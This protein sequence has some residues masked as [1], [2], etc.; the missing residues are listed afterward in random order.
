MA[1]P[2]TGA[3]SSVKFV[4]IA[5]LGQAELDG[6]LEHTEMLAS[7]NTTR[8][9]ALETDHHQLL[10]HNGDI[11]CEPLPPAIFFRAIYRLSSPI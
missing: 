9:L 5:D 6:S 3:A 10:I 4:A 8:R 11:S 7:L 1:P 2:V